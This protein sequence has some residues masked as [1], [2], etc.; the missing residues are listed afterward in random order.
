MADA[1]RLPTQ[2]E[3]AERFGVSTSTINKDLV[4][5]GLI[6]AGN[7][8]RGAHAMTAAIVE[9]SRTGSSV[10]A[11][12]ETVGFSRSAVM[13]VLRRVRFAEAAQ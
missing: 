11:I 3:L 2:R 9:M 8:P 10:H 5:M 4:D 7:R 13:R 12:C 6:S 1:G